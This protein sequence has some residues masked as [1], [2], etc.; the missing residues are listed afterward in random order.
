MTTTRTATV[1]T[2]YNFHDNVTGD[3]LT[4][5]TPLSV[6]LVREVVAFVSQRGEQ[7]T[8]P[9]RDLAHIAEYA[10]QVGR[11]TCDEFVALVTDWLALTVTVRTV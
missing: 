11:M 9:A 10:G 7:A 3:D 6:F 2:T 4:T 8:K 1:T 5:T